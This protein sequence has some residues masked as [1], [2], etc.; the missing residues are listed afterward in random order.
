MLPSGRISI[1]VFGRTG[2]KERMGGMRCFLPVIYSMDET[3]K[4][5]KK[6]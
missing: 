5:Y 3:L 1:G 2:K 6:V 4:V